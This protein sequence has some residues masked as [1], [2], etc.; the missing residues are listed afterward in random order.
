MTEKPKKKRASRAKKA[1]AEVSAET[2]AEV[3]AAAPVE[4]AAPAK[5]EE[6]VAPVEEE[7]PARP[8]RRKAVAADTPVVPVVSSS[9]ADEAKAE[10]KPKRAGW[11]QRKGFF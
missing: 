4:E 10:E 9:V 1:V 2:V 11:W 7:A 3:P 8:T 5:V 6:P